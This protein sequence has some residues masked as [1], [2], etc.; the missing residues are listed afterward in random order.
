LKGIPIKQ[1]QQPT[2]ALTITTT[3]K[4]KTN[5]LIVCNAYFVHINFNTLSIKWTTN[6]KA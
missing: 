6:K 1:Q 3:T 5:I 4:K 2:T